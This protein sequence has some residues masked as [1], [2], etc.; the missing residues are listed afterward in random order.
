MCVAAPPHPRNLSPPHVR[1]YRGAAA[2]GAALQ[3]VLEDMTG[4]RTVPNVFI[5]GEHVGGC[6]DTMRLQQEGALAPLLEG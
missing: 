1:A 5:R 4:Q 2:E 3:A 6:D